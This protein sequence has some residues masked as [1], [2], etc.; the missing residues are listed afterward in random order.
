M[1][2]M[3]PEEIG[4]RIARLREAKELSQ[5]DL[6]RALG[7]SPQAVQKWED[8]GRPRYGRLSA[9]AEALSVTFAQLIKGTI[10]ENSLQLLDVSS[11]GG[12]DTKAPSPA[13]RF[14]EKSLNVEGKLPLISWV[15]A[16]EW[17]DL[18]GSFTEHDAEDWIPCPFKHGKESFCLR[19]VGESMYNP[20]G[21]KS[22][23]PGDFIAVDPSRD[24]INRSMVVVRLTNDDRA[25]FKQLIIDP[26]G[27]RMLKALNP[28]WPMP[29]IHINGN[30]RI[31]GVVIG[32]WVPE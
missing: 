24:P 12:A 29:Y 8:G 32:K 16:G 15:Q 3:E 14:G 21:D 22:Y 30:A 1:R 25:T 17:A 18:V 28:D 27:T 23:A 4:T 31:V 13:Q 20:G 19:V 11:E 7:I 9:I 5:S 6:A 10:Y 26:D 2:A